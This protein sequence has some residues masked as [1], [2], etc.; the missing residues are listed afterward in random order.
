MKPSA[1]TVASTTIGV[2]FAIV[3][4]WALDYCCTVKIPGEVTAA[5]GALLSALI[6]YLWESTRP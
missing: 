6:G 2:P 3:M 4:A 1:N 5:M